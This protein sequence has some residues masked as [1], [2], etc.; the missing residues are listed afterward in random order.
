MFKKIYTRCLSPPPKFGEILVIGGGLDKGFYGN[1][2]LNM[3]ACQFKRRIKLSYTSQYLKNYLVAKTK[4]NF[5]MF[6]T[7][8]QS[9]NNSCFLGILF[10]SILII[11]AQSVMN[12][13]LE[14]IIKNTVDI[15]IDD[16][17]YDN[18]RLFKEKILFSD[19]GLDSLDVMELTL[20]I[21]SRFNTK[22][23]TQLFVQLNSFQELANALAK[24]S[25][26]L[27]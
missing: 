11:L 24:Q 1:I 22:L 18:H 27:E 19:V 4:S 2:N 6:W 23:P 20:A 13:V 14:E 7:N 10:N 12:L 16:N 26:I 5:R 3:F 15:K 9:S 8:Q 17:L 25:T 21:E